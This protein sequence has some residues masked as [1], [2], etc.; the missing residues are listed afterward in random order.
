MILSRKLNRLGSVSKDLFSKSALQASSFLDL[1]SSKIYENQNSGLNISCFEIPQ[2]FIVPNFD[3]VED[4]SEDARK[5]WEI[6]RLLK[7]NNHR[8]VFFLPSQFFL[9]SQLED[10]VA[11]SK[12]IVNDLAC[13]LDQIGVSGPSIVLRIGSAYGARKVTMQ[14]FCD[15]AESLGN[16]VLSKIAVCNDEKPSLF[17]VT[18]LLS[19]VYYT[20]KIPIVF[21][22]LPHQFNNGGL[23]IREALFLS[24][25]TWPVGQTPLFIHSESSEVDQNGIALSPSPS[26]YLK[27]RIPTFGLDIDIV[28]DSP[29]ESRACLKYLSELISLKPMVINKI[30][31]K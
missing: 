22:L 24:V 5:I 26:N 19:G 27:H 8:V 12:L 31:K 15:N 4:E 16:K 30:E 6:Y 21:R 28:I 9:G 2:N 25:S 1:V 23:S 13:F 3:L 17:S 29:I 10:A 18:D 11:S 14:R 7:T 20:S